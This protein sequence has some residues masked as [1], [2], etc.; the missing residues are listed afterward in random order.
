MLVWTS[1]DASLY[2]PAK[3]REQLILKYPRKRKKEEKKEGKKEEE[4]TKG[5]TDQKPLAPISLKAGLL[6]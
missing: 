2:A 4:K 6:V 1:M 3:R 5:K